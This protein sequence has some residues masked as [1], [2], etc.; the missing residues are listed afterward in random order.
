MDSL[1]KGTNT[2]TTSQEQLK[3]YTFHVEYKSYSN[4]RP[5]RS[6]LTYSTIQ[7]N[8]QS[9]IE[10]LLKRFSDKTIFNI[11]PEKPDSNFDRVTIPIQHKDWKNPR[12]FIAV[13]SNEPTRRLIKH[14][15]GTKIL[16]RSEKKYTLSE[17]TELLMKLGVL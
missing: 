4:R 14:S 2:M 16:V 5:I 13:K 1:L 11:T 6:E 8:P 3:K 15:D 9:A 7:S 17:L 12:V 10:A